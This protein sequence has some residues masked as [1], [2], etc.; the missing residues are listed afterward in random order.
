MK[1]PFIHTRALIFALML[2]SGL[3][4]PWVTPGLAQSPQVIER[5]ENYMRSL[6]EL[7]ARF[8]QTGPDGSQLT[9]TFFLDRPGRLR[10]EY[11]PPIKDFVVADGYFIYFYDAQMRQQTNAPI[12]NTL[13]DFILREDVSLNSE[14]IKVQEI[15]DPGGLLQIKLVQR[16]DPH[17]GSI[18]LGFQKDPFRLRRWRVRDAQGTITEIELYDIRRDI[19]LPDRL[20]VYKDPNPA[21]QYN[22]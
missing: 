22:Q 16:A 17:S 12:G 1:K 21:P 4:G 14:E 10:F 3:G 19:D 9:G 15:H 20:F 18:T 7:R 13:A 2:L 8:V 6:D 11:D 5:A